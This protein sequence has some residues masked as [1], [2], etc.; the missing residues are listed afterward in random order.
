[1]AKAILSN[2]L[3][4]GFISATDVNIPREIFTNDSSVG[5]ILCPADP[6]KNGSMNDHII[7]SLFLELDKYKLNVM[8]FT[9]IKT[10]IFKDNYE[11]YIRQTS[12]CVDDFI[13]VTGIKYLI[14]VGYSL[15][16]MTALNTALRRP[17]ETI[18]IILLSPALLH[19][20]MVS[21]VIPFSRSVLLVSGESDPYSTPDLM[22]AYADYLELRKMTVSSYIIPK[23][24]Y[25]LSDEAIDV[26]VEYII[27]LLEN[28]KLLPPQEE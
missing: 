27:A 20:D 17:A 28:L 11:K 3:D 9:Y 6:L 15:G 7:K 2:H 22:K 12:Y 5:V 10:Q 14:F 21:W 25:L 13:Q 23:A 26:T 4:R 19:Y 18:G 16:A 1:M 8:R 24:N